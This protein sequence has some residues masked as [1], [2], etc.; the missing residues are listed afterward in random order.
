[1][2]KWSASVQSEDLF[3]RYNFFSG[4]N[5]FQLSIYFAYEVIEETQTV[6]QIHENTWEFLS[7]AKYANL[8]S[9]TYPNSSNKFP[10][11]RFI[12]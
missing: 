9:K 8:R 5:D 7:N 6:G 3:K 11:E 4:E 2:W 10:I 12:R 1:M